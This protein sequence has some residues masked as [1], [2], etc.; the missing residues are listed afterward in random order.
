MSELMNKMK[1][2]TLSDN[3][4][5]NKTM[6]SNTSLVTSKTQLPVDK[7]D[8]KKNNTIVDEEDIELPEYEKVKVVGRGA[9]FNSYLIYNG[10]Y[11]L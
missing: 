6:T 11:L 1:H 7:E 10:I 5:L 3:G 9:L 8:D 4:F 2:S